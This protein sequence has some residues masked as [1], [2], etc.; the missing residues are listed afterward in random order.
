M[1]IEEIARKLRKSKKPISHAEVPSECGV[2][3]VFLK[4]SEDLK[5]FSKNPDSLIYIGSSSDLSKREF[6]HH[7]NSENT[8]FSTLRRSIGAIFKE[9]F[10]LTAI[11]RSSGSSK[12]NVK[13]YKFLPEGEEKLTNWMIGNLEVGIRSLS[14]YKSIEK[15]LISFL[16]PPLNLKGWDNPYRR[17]IKALRKKCADEARR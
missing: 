14:D 3:G 16:M 10:G 9:E 13:N 4:A 12:T 1:E 5:G 11:P 7:F 17:E 15:S 6:E 2:Y 8:G